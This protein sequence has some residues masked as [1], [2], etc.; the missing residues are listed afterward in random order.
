[1]LRD[2]SIRLR[3]GERVALLGPNGAG[4]STLFDVIAGRLA[5]R[6]GT[7]QLDHHV[8]DRLPQHRRARLGLGYVPQEST[9]FP[10]LSVRANLEAGALSPA[11]QRPGVRAP[12]LTPARTGD[13]DVNEAI[14][15]A[16][17][18]WDLDAIQGRKA[19]ILSGGERRRV[20]VARALLASPSML[21]L[22]EPFAGLD[23]EGRRALQSGLAA[24]PRGV[25]LL[26]T[27]HAHEDVL[28]VCDRAVLLLDGRVVFDGPSMEVTTTASLYRRPVGS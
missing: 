9:V 15:S 26:V 4:K 1:V 27:D 10:D 19:G 13:V 22:D 21:L 16:L 20:E 6:S 12:G 14:D 24:V 2:V 17:L 8:L 11:A 25:S 23:P 28:Q 5:A 3:A 18:H 7:V